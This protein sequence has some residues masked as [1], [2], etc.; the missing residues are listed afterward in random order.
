MLAIRILCTLYHRY[1]KSMK[2][3]DI[4]TE[5]KLQLNEKLFLEYSVEN[6]IRLIM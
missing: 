4:E 1:I 2:I 6:D 5:H 3:Y